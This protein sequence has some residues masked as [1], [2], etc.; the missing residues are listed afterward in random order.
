LGTCLNTKAKETFVFSANDKVKK[1]SVDILVAGGGI[2]G[3]ALFRYF[4]E[5]GKQCLLV[6]Y[7]RGSSWRNIGGG[8]PTFSNPTFPISP[9]IIWK[10]SKKFKRYKI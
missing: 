2:A 1:E 5:A 8:R 3:S 10:Y 9:N 6:N 4:A 7:D